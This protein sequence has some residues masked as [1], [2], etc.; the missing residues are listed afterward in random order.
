MKTPAWMFLEEKLGLDAPCRIS[1]RLV[2]AE[3]DSIAL[4][5]DNIVFANVRID[6]A[7][8]AIG[9]KAELGVVE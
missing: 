5:E 2:P 8:S 4:C 3:A 9:E 7:L 1:M 6:S